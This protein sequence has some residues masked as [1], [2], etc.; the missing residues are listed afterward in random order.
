MSAYQ[1][2]ADE[3]SVDWNAALVGTWE[4]YETDKYTSIYRKNYECYLFYPNGTYVFFSTYGDG[5]SLSEARSE[6]D[7]YIRE[8]NFYAEDKTYSFDGEN[9]TIRWRPQILGTEDFYD[10]TVGEVYPGTLD[11]DTYVDRTGADPKVYTRVSGD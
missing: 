4:Y 3:P 2:S 9:L 1:A 11:G 10:Y 6:R 5:L 7:T 8:R